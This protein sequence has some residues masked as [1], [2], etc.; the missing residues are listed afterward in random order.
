MY[1]FQGLREDGTA[2]TRGTAIMH[3]LPKFFTG[4]FCRRGH[5]AQRYTSTGACVVCVA[6]RGAKG[7]GK[8]AEAEELLAQGQLSKA[9]AINLGSAFYCTGETLDCGHMGQQL[10]VNDKCRMCLHRERAEEHAKLI[11]DLLS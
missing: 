6:E 8:K 10:V 7:A 1:N 11:V 2:P 9:S 4:K 3:D 5:I